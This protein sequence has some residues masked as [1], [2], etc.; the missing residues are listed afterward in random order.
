VSA[1]NNPNADVERKP[2]TL[3]TI[4]R[5]ARDD[6]PFACLT[7]YDF[8]TAKWLERAGIP[9]LLVG[10]SA[11][12]VIL[13]QDSTV[14]APLDFL[15][16]LTAAV[17]RGA[18]NTVVMA[19]MPFNTYH[20]S[21]ETALN[22][23]A[24]FMTEGHADIIKIEADASFTDTLAAMQ[25]AGIPVCAHVGTRP[26]TWAL[27]AGPRISGRTQDEAEQ[28]VRDAVALEQAGA[29]MLLVEAVPPE[30]TSRIRSATSV[31]IIGIGAGTD[32]HGQILVIQDLLGLSDFT[33]KFAEPV[34]DLGPKTKSAAQEWI[35]RV[36][37]REIGGAAYTMKED[38][39]RKNQARQ[40]QDA[41]NKQP[42]PDSRSRPST[43]RSGQVQPDP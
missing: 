11:A 7:A 26:Q 37:R 12:N 4:S 19:D 29:V 2:V 25:R 32:C 18:P 27:T 22:N 10:D 35:R 13:G 21:I 33:P 38:Q 41:E 34:A 43:V 20:A 9:L 15:V 42:A 6:Q 36:A 30:V 17:K 5:M 28:I 23:A 8:T 1:H 24:R 40:G 3:R 14:H 31:P 39:Q 16:T